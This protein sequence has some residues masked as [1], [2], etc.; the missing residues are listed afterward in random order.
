MDGSL[1][2]DDLRLEEAAGVNAKEL[3]H[4]PTDAS[5]IEIVEIESP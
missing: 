5:T 4:E 1:R 3:A 2:P